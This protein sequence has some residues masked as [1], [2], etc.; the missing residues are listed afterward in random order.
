VKVGKQNLSSL[1]AGYRLYG[2]KLSSYPQ[3]CAGKDDRNH[4]RY[5]KEQNVVVDPD[6]ARRGAGHF[7]KYKY[8]KAGPGFLPA[9]IPQ[10]QVILQKFPEFIPHTHVS[11]FLTLDCEQKTI[12]EFT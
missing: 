6:S 9:S 5:D 11:Q 10:M 12:M 3:K 4:E 8:G 7:R 2:L 1:Y